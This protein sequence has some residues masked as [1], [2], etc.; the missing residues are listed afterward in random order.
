VIPRWLERLS[1]VFRKGRAEHELDAEL[2]FHLEKQIEANIAAGM[3][4]DAARRAALRTF[5]GVEQVKE[6]CRDARGV[7]FIE[8]LLQDFR[9]ALRMMR[10]SPAFTAVAVLSL[11]FGIGANTAI[12]SLADA[13]LLKKL[14]VTDPDRLVTI[15]RSV[16]Y[17]FFRELDRRN[18]VLAGLAGKYSIEVHLTAGDST[19]RVHGEL[20]S[21]SYFRVLGV[22]A[23][24]GRVL[25]EEDDGVEGTHSVCVISYDLWQK[26]FAGAPDIL[27]KPILLNARPFQ[28]VGVSERGFRGTALQA[29]SDVLAPMSMT[30]FLV[31]DKRD[32][33]GWSWLQMI[34]RLKP[35]VTRAEAESNIQA[36]GTIIDREQGHEKWKVSY[37][38]FPGDQGFEDRDQFAKPILVLLVLVGSVLLIACANIANLLLARAIERQ[39]EIAVRLA[40]GATRARLLRQL[41]LESLAL[42]GLGGA[43]GFLLSFWMSRAIVYF[44]RN[45]SFVLEVRPDLAALGLTVALSILTALLFGLAPAWQI[46]RP[47]VAPAL[48]REAMGARAWTS[49]AMLRRALLMGQISASLVLVFGAGLFGRTLR[50][51]RTVDLG[52]RPEQIILITM[53][54][55][56]SGY[57]DADTK[58][59]YDRLLE[60]IRKLPGVRAA[61]LANMTILSGNMFAA[62]VSVT[63]Y[64]PQD[65]EPNYYLNWVSPDYFK[66]L[67]TPVLEGRDFNQWDSKG[68][69]PVAIVNERFASRFWPG[70]NAIGKRFRWGGWKFDLE[71]V[72]I[73]ANTKYQT[74]RE[75]PQ[76][77]YYLPVAQQSAVEL[78]L[79][80]RT[81]GAP[82]QMI[83]N[84]RETV[85]SMDSKLPVYNIKTLEA[86]IDSQLSQER[87]LASLS[88]F[89]S[90]AAT[91]LAAIGL[92]GV[93]A[94]SVK[95]RFREIGIRMALGARGADVVMLFVRE[96]LATV[97][98]GIAIGVACAFASA[99]YCASL[100]YGLRYN[101]SNT[102]IAAGLLLLAVGLLAAYLP[103]RKATRVAPI[104]ALRYE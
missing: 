3:T 10:R 88:T 80:V 95:R 103:A 59:L 23:V 92:Y 102:L 43:L 66:T 65:H 47:D 100:L 48:K 12:F 72:G 97:L 58:V 36:V 30:E 87:I 71:I 40:L 53:D 49:R 38:L 75:E 27:N 35:G 8:T 24:L 16:N 69:Q 73:V 22:G 41:L 76:F 101:D 79:Y 96:N 62:D 93:V 64:S 83:S 82:G 11:A 57:Q 61:S 67:G 85:R 60:R 21:G 98:L 32:S 81:V 4:P 56:R 91:L 7:V 39:Q 31:G 50:N 19:E 2:R 13:V 90:G 28:I 99:K 77:I 63:G 9:Y 86:Q 33:T 70:Q 37:P 68:A 14:P 20:V 94:Y 34:G 89:F 45:D 54:P 5:G 29:R 52:F 42:S 6:E 1:F 74:I 15:G 51:L 25:T 18:V 17:P 104:E 84:I 78:T 44:L 55:S 46:T 26:K